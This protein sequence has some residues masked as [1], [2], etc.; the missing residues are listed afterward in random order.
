MC[1]NGRNQYISIWRETSD[2]VHNFPYDNDDCIMFLVK[3]R[4]RIFDNV[5]VKVESTNEIN[6]L[7][8]CYWQKMACVCLYA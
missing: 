6:V 3:V 1:S 8:R 4:C 2:D 7:R 5:C